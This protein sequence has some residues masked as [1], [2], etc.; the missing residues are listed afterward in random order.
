MLFR[1]FTELFVSQ[2]QT[3][4]S[5]HLRQDVDTFVTPSEGQV[6]DRAASIG[7]GRGLQLQHEVS[8]VGL[9]QWGLGVLLRTHHMEGL[10][11]KN[12]FVLFVSKTPD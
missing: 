1:H 10:Q 5:A 12:L 3:N 8:A 7:H 6:K 2:K 11:R 4:R 9:A